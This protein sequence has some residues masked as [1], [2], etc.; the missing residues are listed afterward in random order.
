MCRVVI[1]ELCTDV[2]KV[3]QNINHIAQKSINEWFFDNVGSSQTRLYTNNIIGS[4]S[5]LGVEELFWR[6]VLLYEYE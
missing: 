4:M 5:S 2:C 6:F 3:E 1:T